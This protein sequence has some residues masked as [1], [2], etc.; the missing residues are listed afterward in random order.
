MNLERRGYLY[1][2]CFF[3]S[4]HLSPFFLYSVLGNAEFCY[5]FFWV[6]NRAHTNYTP[7][8]FLTIWR[9][10]SGMTLFLLFLNGG[11]VQA[12]FLGGCFGLLHH[13]NEGVGGKS[14]RSPLHAQHNHHLCPFC[15]FISLA[16]ISGISGLCGQRS[17]I[18]EGKPTQSG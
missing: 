7:S 1:F 15:V 8:T 17:R 14:L 9:S 18:S 12:Y 2:L 16:L 13:T 10:A 11:L 4:S 3:F 6:T 5:Q